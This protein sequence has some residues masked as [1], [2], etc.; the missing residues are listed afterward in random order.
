MLP[1]AAGKK[2]ARYA[3]GTGLMPEDEAPATPEALEKHDGEHAS[4]KSKGSDALRPLYAILRRC[5]KEVR[6]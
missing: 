2:E 1:Q 5:R 3:Y 6:P 4:A